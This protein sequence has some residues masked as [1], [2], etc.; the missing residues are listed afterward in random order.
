MTS[1][2]QAAQMWAPSSDIEEVWREIE[3]R[4]PHADGFIQLVCDRIRLFDG[5][6]W[7]MMQ[8]PS[9]WARRDSYLVRYGLPVAELAGWPNQVADVLVDALA[10]HFFW[11]M[12][13][14]KMDDVLDAP[15]PA[16]DAVAAMTAAVC[17]AS[18]VHT[19]VCERHGLPWADSIVGLL[20]SL[21]ATAAAER[22]ECVPRDQIWRRAT[23]FLIAGRTLL[24]LGDEQDAVF[25]AYINVDGLSHDI[26]DLLGDIRLGIRSL[27]SR[28]FD[29]LDHDR[30]FRRDIVDQWFVRG[31]SE[32]HG[33]IDDLRKLAAVG[34]YPVLDV[35]VQ[36]H[37]E[38]A[39][40]L[41]PHSRPRTVT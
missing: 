6:L 5:E 12:C 17:Q 28:W 9:N 15:Q 3:R 39:E 34:R 14:R 2:G 1:F 8:E 22:R 40:S 30:A 24:K 13:W 29:E 21:C 7:A 36:R 4:V 31:R 19:L 23:P 26:H 41:G 38:V 32:L 37:S 11:S 18:R 20:A 35:L 16:A 33:A 27:P 25:R 10:A